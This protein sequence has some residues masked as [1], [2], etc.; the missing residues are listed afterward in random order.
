MAMF[1]R[2][3]RNYWLTAAAVFI[4]ALYLF[5]IY[6]M[7]TS[8]MKGSAELFRQ[9]PTLWPQA[10]TLDA[11]R[12]IF[13]RD[14]IARYLWN[15]FVIAGGT[16][17]LTLAIGAPAAYGLA[18]LRSRWID[19]MLV[20]VLVIQVLPP[21]LL[22][23]PM[24]AIFRQLELINTRLAVIL[25][26]TTRTLPFALIILR[27]QFLLIPRDLED[28]ARVDGCTRVSAFLR[29]VLPAVRGG[30]VVVAVISFIMAYGDL[31]YSLS[32][33]SRREFQPATVGLYSWVGAEYS[34]W[35]NVMAFATLFTAPVI[36][37]FLLLQRQ[38]VAGLTD[39]ALK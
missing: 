33:I 11:F 15:S 6:W 32:F 20:F 16:V 14:D 26:D 9:P 34:D 39:G 21:A 31:V 5:P 23:T 35:N 22:A 1:A 29:V 19:A 38:I 3:Q 10:P 27:T 7:A 25:A 8:A 28:A 17:A 2:R 37:L 13:E 30:L 36:V 24:F 18:R 12:W 4:A